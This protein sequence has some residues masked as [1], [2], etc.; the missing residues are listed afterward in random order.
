MTKEKNNLFIIILFSSIWIAHPISYD[1]MRIRH[2]ID[3]QE[4]QAVRNKYSILS[5]KKRCS[6]LEDFLFSKPDELKLLE[7]SDEIILP[8]IINSSIKSIEEVQFVSSKEDDN[9]G[10]KT[11]TRLGKNSIF[12][13]GFQAIRTFPARPDLN[14][15][16]PVEKRILKPSVILQAHLRCMKQVGNLPR[17]IIKKDKSIKFDK[18]YNGLFKKNY[19]D[20]FGYNLYLEENISK[21]SSKNKIKQGKQKLFKKYGKTSKEYLRKNLFEN[22]CIIKSE[23]CKYLDTDNFVT[24]YY[25][26]FIDLFAIV[27]SKENCLLDFGIATEVKYAEMFAYKSSGTLKA[28]ELC[29]LPNQQIIND[30]PVNPSLKSAESKE[31]E[32]YKENYILSYDDAIAILEAKYGSSF[33]VVSNGEFK[34]QEWQAVKK[35]EHGVCFGINPADEGFSQDQAKE[36]NAKGG[37]VSYVRKGNKLPSLDLIRAYQNVIKNFCEDRN[38]SD[39]NDESTFRREPSITFFN[40]ET[41][42]VVIFNRE[43]KIFITAYKLAERNVDEYLTTGNI[44]SN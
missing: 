2:P 35:L 31:L 33:I 32:V 40:E 24:I 43:T 5:F 6:T 41:R 4:T 22:P 9:L 25:D 8:R 10:V 42:Q 44:G 13:E 7:K 34:I 28:R 19:E 12:V 18:N 17:Q 14:Y 21:D 36:I 26:Q 3:S 20:V 37:L 16:D 30:F 39:R 11:K 1:E 15:Y 38:Q 29:L 27:D 23:K